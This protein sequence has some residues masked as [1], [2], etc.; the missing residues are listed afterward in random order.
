M[1]N[2]G[3]RRG[4]HRRRARQEQNDADEHEFV[5]EEDEPKV[6][7]AP[8]EVLVE[9]LRAVA[10]AQHAVIPCNVLPA[11]AERPAAAHDAHPEGGGPLVDDHLEPVGLDL[12]VLEHARVL[13]CQ[14]VEQVWHHR[15]EADEHQ[16]RGDHV[17]GLRLV[18]DHRLVS[19]QHLEALARARIWKGRA[20]CAVRWQGRWQKAP[21]GIRGGVVVE[22]FARLTLA[23]RARLEGGDTEEG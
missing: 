22:E 14:G 10:C 15:R 11:R 1:E 12:D 4:T 16:E 13:G 18:A 20:G 8:L 17:E 9:C 3:E 2:G 6:A 7:E 19:L 21:R 23:A 5:E